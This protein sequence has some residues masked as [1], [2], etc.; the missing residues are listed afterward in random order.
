MTKIKCTSCQKEFN[1]YPSRIKAGKGKFCSKDCYTKKM[2]VDPEHR[3]NVARLSR[4]IRRY[5]RPREEIISILGG[6]CSKC[7]RLEN[8]NI[9]HKDMRS[10]IKN[11]RELG[12][13]WKVA[14]NNITNLELLCAPC[15]SRHH[16]LTGT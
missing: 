9:H 13:Y 4:E 1:T 6:V 3:K 15:H 14:N 16:R 11:K 10:W 8:L 2:F 7:G 12:E 5:G